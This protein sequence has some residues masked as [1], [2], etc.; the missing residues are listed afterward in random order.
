MTRSYV[1]SSSRGCSLAHAHRLSRTDACLQIRLRQRTRLGHAVP[2]STLEQV[3]RTL[4][5][6]YKHYGKSDPAADTYLHVRCRQEEAEKFLALDQMTLENGTLSVVR[7]PI[8][9]KVSRDAMAPSVE[10]R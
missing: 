8:V 9:W 5:I 2:V 4:R 1:A 7:K 3:L 6:P 10:P